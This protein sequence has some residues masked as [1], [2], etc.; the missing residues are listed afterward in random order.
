MGHL[1]VLFLEDGAQTAGSVASWLADILAQARLSLDLA[2]YDVHLEGEAADILV[3]ALRERERA[4]VRLRIAYNHPT[5]LPPRDVVAEPARPD[6]NAAFLA[7]HGLQGRPVGDALGQNLMHHKFLLVDAG[8]PGARLWTGSANLTSAAFTRQ[9]NNLL[10][11]ASPPLVD[12][13]AAD[14]EEIWTTGDIAGSGRHD[15]GTA[16]VRYEAEDARVEVRF[17]PGQGRAIDEEVAE[18][19]S[20]ARRE[21]TVASVV[22]TS[23]AILDALAGVARRGLR[24]SG[25]VDGQMQS[26]LEGW[27]RGPGSGWKADTFEEIARYG[28]LHEKPSARAWPAGPHDY[29]HDKVIVVDDTVIT[30]SYNY[31]RNAEAN[32]ENILFIESP[33]L[34]DAYRAHVGRLVERYPLSPSPTGATAA[35]GGTPPG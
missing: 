2:I 31:S 13:Y 10:D 16:V 1:K 7:A 6:E 11:I 17:A 21:V 18:R 22:L 19:I 27:R 5:A 30:G 8:T 26:I 23:G 28:A 29:M 15:G 14:F 32:A 34:A 24:L 3:G 9:E 35:A 20:L 33:A 25:I 4:G 12:A